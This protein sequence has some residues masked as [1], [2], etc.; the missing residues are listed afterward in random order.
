MTH[1]SFFIRPLHFCKKCG[2][3]VVE[4]CTDF[5]PC[6]DSKSLDVV[7]KNEVGQPQKNLKTASVALAKSLQGLE[8]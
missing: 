3:N 5:D 8:F 6:E 1:E 7:K 2:K 4:L